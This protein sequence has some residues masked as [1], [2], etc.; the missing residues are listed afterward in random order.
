MLLRLY[1]TVTRLPEKLK[2]NLEAY[3]LKLYNLQRVQ[4]L[5]PIAKVDEY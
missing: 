4:G 5:E 1:K 2:R 3:S